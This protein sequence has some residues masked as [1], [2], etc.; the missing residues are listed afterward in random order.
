MSDPIFARTRH[1]YDSYQDF[2][3]LVE[4][5]GFDTCY[6]DEIDPASD[7][8][9]IYTPN[10]GETANGWPDARARI[11]WYQLEWETHPNDSGPLPPGVAA[12]W[13]MDKWHA[14]R[15][16]A[17]YVPI[18]SH[19]DLR[20]TLSVEIKG[21][22]TNDIALMAYMGPPRRA[23]MKYQLER[24]GLKI[25]PNAWGLDRHYLLD[26]SRSFV[27]VHQHEDI[28][29]VAALRVALA[30]AY[31]LPYI[32]EQVAD[33]GIF[34]TSNMLFS[35][36][37]HLADFAEQWLTDDKSQMLADY[38]WALHQLLCVEKPFRHWIEA[39]L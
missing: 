7:H 10:N 38:G 27:H 29:G 24:C 9:Y 30:A 13:T 26:H 4:L 28:P 2:W 5:S 33:R 36:Y 18:G 1:T 15:I 6:V 39:A 19:A 16:G 20:Y 3:G 37:A 32:S 23:A 34:S 8:T 21:W 14:E 12:K 17:Q 22:D 25:A 11:T 35:D 31:S